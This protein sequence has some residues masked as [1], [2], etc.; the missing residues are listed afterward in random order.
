MS[1]DD[2]ERTRRRHQRQVRHLESYA[3]QKARKARRHERGRWRDEDSDPDTGFAKMH[4]RPPGATGKRARPADEFVPNSAE[5]EGTVIWLGRNREHTDTLAKPSQHQP[6]QTKPN[7]TTPSQAKHQ[8]DQHK[9]Q[10]QSHTRTMQ[11]N[12]N[13]TLMHP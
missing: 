2:K 10:S 12:N 9:L 6:G 1:H 7:P 8:P 13:T 3:D 5:F 11:T 4:R